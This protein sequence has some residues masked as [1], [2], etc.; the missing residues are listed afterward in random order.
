MN[1]THT[2]SLT[3]AFLPFL[4]TFLRFAYQGFWGKI[5]ARMM[6]S[7]EG[8]LAAAGASC[9]NL[10]ALTILVGWALP[11]PVAHALPRAAA[12]IQTP[13][14]TTQT[15]KTTTTQTQDTAAL[16]KETAAEKSTQPV[17]K[18]RTPREVEEF[19]RASARKHGLPESKVVQIAWRESKFIP[20]VR[21]K[22]GRYVGIYQF[23]LTTWKNTPEG[24][25]GHRREDPVANI[26]AAHWLMRTRGFQP[27]A[28]P[29]AKPRRQKSSR[30]RVA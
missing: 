25:A 28:L 24:R 22:S 9:L 5:P 4:N 2:R 21:S 7:R 27:W 10:I 1:K 18:L 15:T 19:I 12:S 6:N 14:T 26:N 17:Q 11:A 16:T 30:A 8:R 13:D 3:V 29:G 20:H 23:D